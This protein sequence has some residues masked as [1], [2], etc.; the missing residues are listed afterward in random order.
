MAPVTEFPHFPH[1]L[2][3]G[4]QNLHTQL[5]PAGNRAQLGKQNR[6]S[7]T[8]GALLITTDSFP[9]QVEELPF[10]N[11]YFSGFEFKK[12]AYFEEENLL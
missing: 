1:S 7:Q 4:K 2:L 5:R 11:N 8:F 12:D 9:P 10:S 6:L 3:S